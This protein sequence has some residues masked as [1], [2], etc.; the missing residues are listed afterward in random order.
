M[1]GFAENAKKGVSDGDFTKVAG[2]WWDGLAKK[3]NEVAKIITEP[4]DD[5]PF[6]DMKRNVDKG[7]ESKYQGFGSDTVN[8]GGGSA[9]KL[10]VA[11]GAGEEDGWGDDDDDDDIDVSGGQD[12]GVLVPPAAPAPQMVGTVVPQPVVAAP[13][14][15]VQNLVSTLPPARLSEGIKSKPKPVPANMEDFFSSFGA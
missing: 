6:S 14:A 3:A 8:R 13:P 5:D 10:D 12:D 15:A 2:S 9:V 11:D 1:G 7:G 4:D